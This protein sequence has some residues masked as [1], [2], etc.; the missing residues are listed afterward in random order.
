MLE[1]WKSKEMGVFAE[2]A[3]EDSHPRK[4]TTSPDTS[5]AVA[6]TQIVVA[7][8]EPDITTRPVTCAV[9]PEASTLTRVFSGVTGK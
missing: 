6:S 2:R 7:E 5:K 8:P 9:F 4:P 1:T 3:E